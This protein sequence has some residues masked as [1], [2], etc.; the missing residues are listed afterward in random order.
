MEPVLC[1]LE[2]FNLGILYDF[3]LG[4]CEELLQKRRQ[5]LGGEEAL[6][7][8]QQGGVMTLSILPS[9]DKRRNATSHGLNVPCCAVLV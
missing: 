7:H 4:G 8:P 5:V 9:A 1:E 3:S 2:P 6:C